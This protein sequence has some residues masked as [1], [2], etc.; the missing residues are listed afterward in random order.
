MVN[1]LYIQQSIPKNHRIEDK[2]TLQRRKLQVVTLCKLNP[3]KKSVQRVTKYMTIHVYR[4]RDLVHMNP[5]ILKVQIIFFVFQ[6]FLKKIYL[7]VSNYLYHKYAKIL[8][9]YSVFWATQTWQTCRSEYVY[10]QIY[11]FIRFYCFCVANDT[12]NFV[13]QFFTYLYFPSLT[14]FRT[15]FIIFGNL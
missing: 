1:C 14:M 7:D 10:F 11:K 4:S 13:I 8:F 12:I 2:T 9:K 15:N 5:F 3:E 6:K